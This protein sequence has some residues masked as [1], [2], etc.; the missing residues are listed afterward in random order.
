MN[1]DE[2]QQTDPTADGTA[3]VKMRMPVALRDAIDAHRRSGGYRTRNACILA[4]LGPQVGTGSTATDRLLG[5]I[6]ARLATMLRRPPRG[7]PLT[8]VRLL[9]AQ[10]DHIVEHAL[11]GDRRGGPD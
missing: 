3:E 8:G 2:Q 11:A 9:R 1:R 7:L 10:I 6:N 4:L 5:E